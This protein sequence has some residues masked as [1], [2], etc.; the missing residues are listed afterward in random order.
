[1][2]ETSARLLRLLSLLQ[3]RR[4]WPGA[5]LA[6]H[7]GVSTRT[8]RRDIDKLRDLDYPI[9]VG[10]G[11]AGG[12]RLGAG[13]RLPPLLL[14]DDEAVAVAVS[15]RTA[16]GS[17]VAGI[18]ETA[19]RAL[20]KLEQVLPH[21]LWRRIEAL[22]V[23]TVQTPA[24]PAV[25]ADELTAVATACRDH[26][27]L[28]FDYRDYRGTQSRRDTEPHE[29]VTWGKRWYLVAWDLDRRDWRTFRV[30]RISTRTPTGPR[31][32]PR[33]LPGGDAAAFVAR[34]VDQ[35]WPHQAT[36]KLH[37]PADSVIA[38]QAT[39]YGRI[40]PVDDDS[41]RLHFGA[42][43]LHS[44]AFL[45][46]ALDVEFEVEHPPELA[47][48]LLRAAARYQRAAAKLIP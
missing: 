37:V 21:R 36:V 7:L 47:E 26:E 8:V 9:D 48:E 25:E 27:R 34:S 4:E 45:L 39:T 43:T 16:T 13:G 5:E 14:D 31:F 40:E 28:R 23:S 35:A 19:L 15:L 12:Y 3:T 41:C 20:L 24:V 42:D 38:Q 1:M 33:E 32:S 18:G 2:K 44:L 11:P 10:M 6:D 29:L 46:G 22:R 30:D 17:G